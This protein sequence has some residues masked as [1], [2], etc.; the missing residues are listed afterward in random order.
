[1]VKNS[2]RGFIQFPLILILATLIGLGGMAAV[3]LPEIQKERAFKKLAQ[4]SLPSGTA[5]ENEILVKFRPDVSLPRIA[6]VHQ[7]QQAVSKK[8]IKGINVEL[9]RLTSRISLKEAITKYKAL[10]EVEFAEPNFLAQAFLS[11]NDPLYPEQWNLQKILSNESFDVSLGGFSQIAVVDTGVDP[12]HPDLAGLIKQGFNT[13]DGTQDSSDDHGHGTHVAGIAA[14]YTNN[15]EGIA[16]VS[17]KST[18]LPVKVLNKDGIG[19]YADVAE[20][21]IWATDNSSRI[22]NLSLGGSSDSETLKRAVNYALNKG[23]L[24]IAAAGNNGNDAPVYPASYPGVLAISASDQNDSLAGFSSFGKNIFVASPG[25]SI[26]STVLAGSYATYH[27]T[28]T[29]APHLSGLL[30]LTLAKQEDL[31]NNQLIE[32]IKQTADKTGPYPYDENGWNQYFGYG[33]INAG[34]TLKETISEEPTPTPTPKLEEEKSPPPTERMPKEYQFTF[35]LQGIVENFDAA[36]SKLV[37]KVDGGTP[38]VMKIIS[39]NLVDLYVD[40][41][42]RI[43]YQG[44]NIFSRELSSGTRVN[45]KGNVVK[46]KLLAMDVLVQHIPIVTPTRPTEILPEN[47]QNTPQDMLQLPQQRGQESLQIQLP[48]QTEQRGKVRGAS[49]TPFWQALQEKILYLFGE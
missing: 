4:E 39:G 15:G 12:N 17:F 11:P 25:V 13:I 31:S 34:K 38:D 23:S 5:L 14:A 32:T 6:Q 36:Q 29:A 2:V 28:S 49:T 19:T 48:A 41:Q 8:K 3:K 10:A 40:S 1:M 30:A 24:L 18:I 46:N 16:S 37:I 26:T 45:V 47:Q 43:K 27:G 20:G 9:V 42:T 44:R 33:R 21:I 35:E 7:T 22:I